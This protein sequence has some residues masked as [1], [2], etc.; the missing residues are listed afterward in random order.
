M[1]IIT[2]ISATLTKLRLSG[3]SPPNTRKHKIL[4]VKDCWLYGFQ[5]DFFQE[6]AVIHFYELGPAQASAVTFSL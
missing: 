2:A 6:L 4:A 1:L 3:H 5:S